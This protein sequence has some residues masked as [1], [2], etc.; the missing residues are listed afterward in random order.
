MIPL[1]HDFA[2]ERVLVVGGGPVGARKARKFAR[3]AEVVVLSPTFE[4]DS[5]GGSRKLR[6]A[7]EPADAGDWLD[8][9]DPVL[10]VAATDSGELND[11][12]ERAADERGLLSNRA[13]YA[14]PRTPGHVVVPATVR[15][16]PVVAA[17]STG[18]RSPALSRHLRQELESTI[19]GA[20]G[21]ANLTG[22]LRTELDHLDA[23]ARRSALRAVIDSDA[24]WKALD[25]ES[26][27]ARQ[28]A[29]DVIADVTG[30]SL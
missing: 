28:V 20:G 24:V 22:S 11:A 21:M 25:T 7:P 16:D 27:N 30:D 9:V 29:T 12:F 13:D 18:A 14:G 3:E 2:G 17:I 15:D 6:A 23:E 1:M 8:R 19:S 10:V 4:A 26:A 5:Y